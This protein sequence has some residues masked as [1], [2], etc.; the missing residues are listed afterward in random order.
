[1]E[2]H[3]PL[4]DSSVGFDI[5]DVSNS[6]GR[7]MVCPNGEIRVSGDHVLVLSEVGG[8]LDHTL[9]LEIARE[10]ILHHL[11]SILVFLYSN[12]SMRSA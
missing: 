7:L 12:N 3:E 5:D 11:V 8:E 1:M 9:R 6:G 10:R 4:L 2:W